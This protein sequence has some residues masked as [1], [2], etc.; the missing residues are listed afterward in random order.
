[1]CRL[2]GPDL[3]KAEYDGQNPGEYQQRD[4][5]PAIPCIQRSAEVDGHDY[6]H[7]GA[8]AQHSTEVVEIAEARPELLRLACIKS[9]DYEDVYGGKASTDTKVQVETPTP[10]SRRLS[11]CSANHRAND[12]TNT[13]C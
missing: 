12:H 11:K 5:L 8:N 4:D 6:T 13:K 1:M 2:E 3:R 10:C 7:Q 9:W